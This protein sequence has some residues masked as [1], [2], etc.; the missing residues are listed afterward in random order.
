MSKVFGARGAGDMSKVQPFP[1]DYAMRIALGRLRWTPDAFWR[2]TPR[3]L[4]R[5]IE[6]LTGFSAH[7]APLDRRALGGLMAR[8][9]DGAG[10]K[11]G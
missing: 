2:A 6:G 3:E 4:A 10:H 7:A 5:A 1:W 8:F 9:P 11:G